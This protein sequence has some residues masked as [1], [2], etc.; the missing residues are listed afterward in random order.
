LLHLTLWKYDGSSSPLS[1]L[2]EEEEEER[3]KMCVVVPDTKAAKE[4][5]LM[6]SLHKLL[7][8]L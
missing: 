2:L 8:E 5:V 7:N 3:G 1:F 4:N 6:I